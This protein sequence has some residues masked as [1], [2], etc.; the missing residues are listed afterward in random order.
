MIE[1]RNEKDLRR[2]YEVLR[3]CFEFGAN[4]TQVADLKRDIRKYLKRTSDRRLIKSDWD[5]CIVL[6]TLPDFIDNRE[7][8]EEYFEAREYICPRYPAYD[9]TGRPFTAWHKV[10]KRNDRWMIYHCVTTDV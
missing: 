10:F 8:A 5:N 7:D 2:A 1:I 4:N 3:M 9:C 6:V